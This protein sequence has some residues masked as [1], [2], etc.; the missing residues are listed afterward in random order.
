MNNVVSDIACIYSVAMFNDNKK[1]DVK[2]ND[3]T[4]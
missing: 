3:I 1:K 2:S 4:G